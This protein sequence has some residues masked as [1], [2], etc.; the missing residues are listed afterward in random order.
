MT[1]TIIKCVKGPTEVGQMNEITEKIVNMR[2]KSDVCG[3][4]TSSN[5]KKAATH[6]C[7]KIISRNKSVIK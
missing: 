7:K 3:H 2:P 5:G 4:K 6:T 1:K